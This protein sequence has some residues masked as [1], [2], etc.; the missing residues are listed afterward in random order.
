MKHFLLLKLKPNED[1]AEFAQQAQMLLQELCDAGIGI[2]AVCVRENR[3]DRPDNYD[4][5]A[6][7]DMKDETALFTYVDH[8]LH[9]RFIAYAG[10]KVAQKNSFDY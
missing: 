8:P 3:V 2:N 10:P 9:K 5:M 1:K 4:I 7:F 6:E